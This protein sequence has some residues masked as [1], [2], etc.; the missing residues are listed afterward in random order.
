MTL[1]FSKYF[2]QYENHHSF[3]D[4]LNLSKEVSDYIYNHDVIKSNYFDSFNETKNGFELLF[5]RSGKK[6]YFIDIK[7]KVVKDEKGDEQLIDNV[8]ED[9][10]NLYNILKN[11][12][13]QIN[14]KQMDEKLKTFKEIFPLNEGFDDELKEKLSNE[15][16]SLKMGVLDLLDKTLKGDV[17]KVQ[18]FIDDY[19]ESNSEEILEGF[20]EDADLMDFYLKYQSDIDQILLDNKYYDDP[21]EVESLYDYVIDGTYDAVV[22]VM[23]EIKKDIYGEK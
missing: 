10:E 17:T 2:E 18:K 1:N 6:N 4:L 16:L 9:I 3:T 12:E 7:N 11:Y 20:V 13:V 8:Y 22:W 19:I 14:I 5:N 15:Y 23:E 21:P